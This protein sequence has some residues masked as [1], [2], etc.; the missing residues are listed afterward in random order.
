[1]LV[2]PGVTG[3]VWASTDKGLFHSTNSGTTFTSISGVTQAWSIGFGA[4][5]TTG[6]YPAI[7][8]A[9]NIDGV[10]YFRSDDAGVN[11]VKINDA[12][13]GFGAISGN[14]LTGDPRIHGR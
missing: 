9:A 14:V 3:D 11:W 8:A 2:N 7:F 6:G 5:V 1:M 12:A 4:P 10:G 13:H